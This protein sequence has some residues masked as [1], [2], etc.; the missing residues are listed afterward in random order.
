MAHNYVKAVVIDD[1][2]ANVEVLSTL[3]ERFCNDVK[4]V[5]KF[6]DVRFAVEQIPTLKPDLVFLDIE[7]PE[8]DGF[9][10]LDSLYPFQFEIVFVTAFQQ[11]A[12]KAIKYEAIDYLLKPVSIDELRIA[13]DRVLHFIN[14]KNSAERRNPR[15]LDTVSEILQY[16][17]KIKISMNGEHVF[18]ELNEVVTIEADGPSVRL[19][20]KNGKSYFIPYSLKDFEDNLRAKNFVRIHHSFII[21][22]NHV[23]RYQKGNGRGLKVFMTNGQLVEVSVRKK[24]DFFEVIELIGL[25]TN[26]NNNS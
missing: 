23:V 2:E 3:L 10:L 9:K 26:L 22:I 17:S 7:M 12:F 6:I 8:I 25:S 21:N 1:E 16:N 24:K 14:M 15:V 5:G 18:H 11:Y 13:V 20:L 19:F 4:V